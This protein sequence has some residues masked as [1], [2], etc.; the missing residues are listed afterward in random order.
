[1]PLTQGKPFG[2]LFLDGLGIQPRNVLLGFPQHLWVEQV[3]RKLIRS[4][5]SRLLLNLL[6]HGASMREQ[7][8]LCKLIEQ[9]G[10]DDKCRKAI[11]N[12]RWPDGVRCPSCKSDKISRIASRNQFDCDSCRYQFSATA[13]T[14]FHDTHLPLHK[15][16]LATYLLCESKKGMAA[17][18]MQR[19][20][21]TTYRTS[22]YL[23]HRIRAA[24]LEVA[25]AKLD[26]TVEIDETYVGGKARRWRPKSEKAV[27]I[28][29]RKR[30]GELRLV[31]AKDATAATIR[32]IIA[33]HVGEDV[34]VIMTD[35]AAIYPWALNKL[36]KE[37]HKTINHSKEYAHGDIHTNTVES[38]F[39]LLKRGIVGTWHKVSAK[40]LPAYLDEMCFRFNNRKNP[41][42]FRDT[43]TKLVNTSNL[44][45]KELTATEAEPAA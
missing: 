13:G 14:I 9:Y 40:H 4:H 3:P 29:I 6:S 34:E 12:F 1:M 37:K 33:G 38:A 39:S 44:E 15:W 10:D 27:V 35:E 2:R 19:M 45:Y 43:L 8:D 32:G 11:E 16:F 20:L 22:W 41:Y 5:V 28:G 21:R 23:C 31:R 24:M 36:P 17:L 42:L 25:P 7:M 30:N 18:Q 26:G